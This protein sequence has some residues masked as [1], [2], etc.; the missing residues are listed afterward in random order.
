MLPLTVRHWFHAF[1]TF[2]TLKGSGNLFVATIVHMLATLSSVCEHST[3]TMMSAA[4]RPWAVYNIY[5]SIYVAPFAASENQRS[6]K[7]DLFLLTVKVLLHFWIPVFC[8]GLRKSGAFSF[9]FVCRSLVS[10]VSLWLYDGVRHDKSTAVIH[11]LLLAS[12]RFVC[13]GL[14]DHL[15][16]SPE[17]CLYRCDSH[18]TIPVHLQ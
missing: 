7:S 2:S 8:F 4:S 18:L 6:S 3:C 15:Y 16:K 11:C 13:M 10:S 9:T 14:D 1:C 17:N 12:S 5:L